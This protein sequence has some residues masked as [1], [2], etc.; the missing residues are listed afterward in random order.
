M[1]LRLAE[2]LRSQGIQK[3]GSGNANPQKATFA[4]SRRKI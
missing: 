3:I 2:V 4:E 1:Y